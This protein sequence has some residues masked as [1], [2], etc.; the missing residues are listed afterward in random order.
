MSVRCPCS[1]TTWGPPSLFW[2]TKQGD[3]H[4]FLFTKSQTT[5]VKI[6]KGTDGKKGG[7]KKR[8]CISQRPHLFLFLW[9]TCRFYILCT[10]LLPKRDDKTQIRPNVIIFLSFLN[11]IEINWINWQ[12]HK[13]NTFN[14]LC[15]IDFCKYM[16]KLNLMPA[17]LQWH[18]SWM[19]KRATNEL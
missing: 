17:S 19:S 5:K 11:W 9:S 16:L 10:T 13:D 15:V 14:V 2:F 7:M 18:S 3:S 6:M 1:R 4:A 12:Q 8:L